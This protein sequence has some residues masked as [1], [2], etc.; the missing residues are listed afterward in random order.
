MFNVPPSSREDVYDL[1][2]VRVHLQ[3]G[4]S[5]LREPSSSSSSSSS[6]TAR[7]F[8]LPEISRKEKDDFSN[9]NKKVSFGNYVHSRFLEGSHSQQ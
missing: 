6:S 2:I 7:R 3:G 4:P 5:L 9:R 8:R 1:A